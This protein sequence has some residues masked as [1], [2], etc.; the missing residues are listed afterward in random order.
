M[1]NEK[2]TLNLPFRKESEDIIGDKVFNE[3]KIRKISD[4]SANL[5]TTVSSL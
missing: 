1:S 3:I 4:I 2:I 5:N